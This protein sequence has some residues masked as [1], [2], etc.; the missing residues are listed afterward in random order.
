MVNSMKKNQL[1]PTK[2]NPESHPPATM[3]RIFGVGMDQHF[4]FNLRICAVTIVLCV[5][6]S[7][8]QM[9]HEKKTNGLTFH[10]ILVV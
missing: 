6:D 1:K 7:I 3:S 5:C 2:E 4:A 8:C 9:S 10:E